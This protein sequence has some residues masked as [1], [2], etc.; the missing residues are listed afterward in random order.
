MRERGAA[1]MAPGRDGDAPPVWAEGRSRVFL[2][3]DAELRALADARRAAHAGSAR[4]VLVDGPPGMGKSALL[5]RFLSDLGGVHILDASGDELET[6]TTYGVVEQLLRAVPF[7]S[8]QL[9]VSLD[10]TSLPDPPTVG[11]ELFGLLGA[12]A[13]DAPVVLVVDDVHWADTASLQALTFALRRL[14]SEPVLALLAVRRQQL[15]RLPSGLVGL[16]DSRRGL[17]VPLDG[18]Q[19][20][21]LAE[22]AW[23]LDRGELSHAAV[24]RLHRHTDGNPLHARALLEELSAEELESGDDDGSLPAPRAFAALLL[25]RLAG[26]PPEAERLAAA[27]A[28]LGMRSP[29]GTAAR[30]AGVDDAL[31]ALQAGVDANLLRARR[32]EGGHEVGFPHVLVR[33]A[34]YHHHLGPARA[35]ELHR[36]AAALVDDEAASLRHRAAASGP[37]ADLADEAADF[38]RREAARGA[39]PSAAAALLQ[40][41]RLSPARDDRE[42]RRRPGRRLSGRPTQ[43]AVPHRPCR[44]VLPRGRRVPGRCLGRGARPR[45]AAVSATVDADQAWFG[46]LVHAVAAWASARGEWDAATRHVEAAQRAAHEIGHLSGQV[47]AATAAARLAYAREDHHRVLEILSPLAARVDELGLGDVSNPA[48]QPWALL[49]AEARLRTGQ[50]DRASDYGRLLEEDGHAPAVLVE[51][52]RL[53]GLLAA[54]EGDARAAEEAF[55]TGLSHAEAAD[56]PFGHALLKLD[57]GTFLRREG[58]RRAARQQLQAAHARLAPLGARPSLMRC[59]RELRACG[60]EPGRQEATGALRRRALTPQES[61]VAK[62]VGGG[63]SNRE[64]AAAL[65]VS[66]KAV[67]Y[68]LSNI[69]RKLGIRS[70]SELAARMAEHDPPAVQPGEPT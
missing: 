27:A 48:I 17:R 69:Y 67:E 50:H 60:A 47:W 32:G 2:G 51:V 11:I 6:A 45:H 1:G 58:Q 62:L 29:L 28:V 26:C 7:P 68:H 59:E 36:R 13:W 63:A 5:R 38:A 42:R 8:D 64:A 53:R 40:A 41:A 15:H 65:F 31:G 43:R 30:L 3:R 34:V 49:Q 25:D 20:P 14:R 21:E 4:A 24:E 9:P 52:H 54:A 55:R 57:Y 33:A 10:Q 46:P 44:V 56:A 19:P 66:V 12:V 16:A 35:A 18:L 70:R 39:W 23:R 61:A 22:L 37:Q